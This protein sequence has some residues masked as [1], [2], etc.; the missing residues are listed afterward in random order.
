MKRLFAVYLKKINVFMNITESIK[1]FEHGKR[2]WTQLA[3]NR[4]P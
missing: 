3:T 1:R 4:D 2:V